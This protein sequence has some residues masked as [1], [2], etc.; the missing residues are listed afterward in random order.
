M[1]GKKPEEKK[2]T[3]SATDKGAGEQEVQEKPEGQ[4]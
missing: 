4:Q 2:V 3:E 1:E